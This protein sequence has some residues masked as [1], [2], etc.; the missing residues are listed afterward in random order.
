MY[1]TLPAKIYQDFLG[2]Q[3]G[4]VPVAA[5]VHGSWGAVLVRQFAEA[6]L[7]G[8][9]EAGP[10]ILLGRYHGTAVALA[11]VYGAPLAADMTFILVRAGVRMVLQTG[12]FGGLRQDQDGDT[13]LVPDSVVPGEGVARSFMRRGPLVPTEI[14][15]LRATLSELGTPEGGT[16]LSTASITAETDGAVR[17]WM[18]DGYAGVDLESAATVAV[19]RALGA[20]VGVALHAS[21]NLARGESFF[22]ERVGGEQVRA[23]RR[24]RVSRMLEL[25]LDYA[26]KAAPERR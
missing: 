8:L 6:H 20:K 14:A 2:V 26:V 12:F 22:D 9:R 3:K 24:Q 11:N 15:D 10:P 4:E 13:L 19:A 5:V 25:C 1:R 18:L 16:L 7:H 21:D 17:R 23:R